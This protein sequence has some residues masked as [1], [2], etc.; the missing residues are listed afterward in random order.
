MLLS[1]L[2]CFPT[3]SS[4]SWSL[5]VPLKSLGVSVEQ[6]V[7]NHLGAE[8]SSQRPLSAFHCVDLDVNCGSPLAEFH[9]R[10]GYQDVPGEERRYRV[11]R[12]DDQTGHRVVLH[13]EGPW[14]GNH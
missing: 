3:S 9:R 14:T 7:A 1:Y 12:G 11:D 13:D 4:I 2:E 5:R 10:C 8:V 6:D